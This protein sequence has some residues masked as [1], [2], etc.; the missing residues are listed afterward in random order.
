MSDDFDL[1]APN[2]KILDKCLRDA[3]FVAEERAGWLLGSYSMSVP[4]F[5]V[6]VY[7]DLPYRKI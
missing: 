7:G 2:D 1:F 6:D 4:I 5:V 3:G